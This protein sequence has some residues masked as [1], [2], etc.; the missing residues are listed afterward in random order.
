MEL[1]RVPL[2][3][4]ASPGEVLRVLRDDRMPF[5][6]TGS[7]GA[8]AAVLGSEP[9]RVVRGPEALD[10]VD[11]PEVPGP[12]GAIGGGWFGY[13]GFGL[14]AAIERL[15]PAPPR[16]APLAEAVLGFYDH[17]LR[18]DAGGRWWFEA[19]SSD[20]AEHRLDVLRARLTSGSSAGRRPWRL[21]G[22]TLG[23]AGADGHRA[24]V[25]ECV[26]RI[27][28]GELFQA[29]VCLRLEGA[30]TG[31]AADAFADAA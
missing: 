2:D 23:G 16:P 22:M 11:L 20:A 10:A 4:T 27:A 18:L 5:A 14:G 12:A 15:P 17:V 3:V 24:A 9:I 19:L 8:S 6:L 29:N 30:F 31:S 28:A 21:D 13:L 25:A 1:L 26:E 7:W